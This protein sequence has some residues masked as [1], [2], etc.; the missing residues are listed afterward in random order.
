MDE[1]LAKINSGQGDFDIL[2]G[3]NVWAVGRS[4]AAGLI[5]PI[6]HDYVPNLSNFMG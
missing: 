5:R 6:N 4:I 2:F 1:G 3:M